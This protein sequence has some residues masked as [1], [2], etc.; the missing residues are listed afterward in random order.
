MRL[1]FTSFLPVQVI[2]LFILWFV[3]LASVLALP[4]ETC[5]QVRYVTITGTNSTPNQ[6]HQLGQRYVGFTGSHQLPDCHGWSG[7]GGRLN[8]NYLKETLARE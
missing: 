7:L 8:L 5:A 2:R 4:I 3:W 6:C 1:R